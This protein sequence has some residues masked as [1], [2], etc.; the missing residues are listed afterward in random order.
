MQPLTSTALSRLSDEVGPPTPIL[1]NRY[2]VRHFRK[3]DTVP[4]E[5]SSASHFRTATGVK[6][7][8]ASDQLNY[9]YRI[10]LDGGMSVTEA[11]KALS[12]ESG[13]IHVQPNYIYRTFFIPNDPLFATPSGT[14][15]PSTYQ[16]GPRLINLPQAWSLASGNATMI[17]GIIDTGIDITHPDLV[18][19]IW[20]NPGETATNLSDDDR[21]GYID[22]IH[23]WNFADENATVYTSTESHGTH[24]SGI[25]A[26][27][28]NNGIGI[29][30]AS[31]KCTIMPLRVFGEGSASAFSSD[32]I[33]ALSYALANGAGV[34]S[35]S[36]GFDGYDSLLGQKVAQLIAANVVVVAAAG[37]DNL[38]LD[39]SPIYPA[40]FPNVISVCAANSSG[41]LD[42]SYSNYGTSA[43]VMAPGTHIMS[44]LPRNQYGTVSG[45][46]MAC[47]MVAG[48]V[49][50]LKS[51]RP[52]LSVSAVRTVLMNTATPV[53]SPTRSVTC[54]LVN[55]RQAVATILLDTI[56]PSITTSLRSNDLISDTAAWSFSIADNI[57][58]VT[59]S[60]LLQTTAGTTRRSYTTS[61]PGFHY[62][63]S[64]LTVDPGSV[65]FPTSGTLTVDLSAADP[66][67]NVGTLSLAL[68][69]ELASDMYGPEG[70]GKPILCKPNPFDPTTSSGTVCFQITQDGRIELTIYSL[71]LRQVRKLHLTSSAGYC[72]LAWD[73]ADESGHIVPNGMYV[74]VLNATLAGKT[75]IKKVKIAVLRT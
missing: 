54:R 67:G 68:S 14:I 10:Y 9:V 11:V 21:N 13:V 31:G 1:F 51:I 20:T 7:F 45:T 70:Q 37:N 59:S 35:M 64:T 34:V 72:E 40:S 22:D 39:R 65:V 71:A 53:L 62:S 18:T 58:I 44:T 23:G 75:V 49:G 32:V 42:S 19:K 66:S 56:A 43:T 30:G 33:Q 25:A 12:T 48:V 61:S 2:R 24:V 52:S 6:K 55:A 73:G 36:L 41:T 17:I 57:A 38:N 46:S 60:I 27:E 28:T 47:P 16:Y 69:R 29:A 63:Q 15:S 5:R 4:S 3:M 50:I 74:G 26:G 8:V